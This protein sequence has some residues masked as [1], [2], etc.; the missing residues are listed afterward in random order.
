MMDET[1]E[2]FPE[3][4]RKHRAQVLEYSSG[5]ASPEELQASRRLASPLVARQ[6]LEVVVELQKQVTDLQKQF[7]DLRDNPPK[8]GFFG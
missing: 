8:R 6:T 7:K 5:P 2:R 4:V 1:P 3:E